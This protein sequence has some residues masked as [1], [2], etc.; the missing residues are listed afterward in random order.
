MRK[1][2]GAKAAKMKLPKGAGAHRVNGKIVHRAVSYAGGKLKLLKGCTVST[3]AGLGI[4]KFK[5]KAAA[6]AHA[7]R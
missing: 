3:L 1:S 2:K 4:A 6:V 7:K 5:T